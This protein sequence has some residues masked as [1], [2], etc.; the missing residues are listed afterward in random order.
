MTLYNSWLGAKVYEV[1][2]LEYFS[3]LMV[4]NSDSNLSLFITNGQKSWN[5]VLAD[6]EH[7][8]GLFFTSTDDK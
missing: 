4:T 1:N 2:N 7:N 8:S 3:P 5:L 6:I